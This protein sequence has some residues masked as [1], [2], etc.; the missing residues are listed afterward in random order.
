MARDNLGNELKVGDEVV[1]FQTGRYSFIRRAQI[2]EIKTKIK[3]TYSKPETRSENTT[4]VYPDMC[5]L[6]HNDGA[7]DPDSTKVEAAA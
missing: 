5:V 4:W 7:Q 1:Y 2:V 6:I 3:V